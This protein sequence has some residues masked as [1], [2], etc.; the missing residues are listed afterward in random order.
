[1][2]VLKN[3]R[4]LAFFTFTRHL[5]D[6]VDSSRE[7]QGLIVPINFSLVILRLVI[8]VVYVIQRVNLQKIVHSPWVL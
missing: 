1:M 3:R 6:V 5:L 8:K 7:K 2:T 4:V